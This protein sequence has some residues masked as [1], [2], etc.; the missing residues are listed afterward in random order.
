MTQ[1]TLDR[2]VAQATGE[3]LNEIR[4]RGFNLV[5]P[6]EVDFDPEPEDL[7]P[8]MIDWDQYDLDRNVAIVEQ[9]QFR[10]TAA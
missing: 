7:L 4:R 10:R 8:E 5:D 3:D 9:R 6:V 2:A 1:D